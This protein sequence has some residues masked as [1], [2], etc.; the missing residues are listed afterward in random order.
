MSDDLVPLPDDGRRYS[1]AREVRLADASLTGRLRLDALAR[2]LQDIANDDARDAIGQD[3]AA[4]VVRKTTVDVMSW[5]R[6]Q[7]SIELT[8]FCGGVGGRW[9]ERSTSFRG[10]D[11]GHVE[12]AALWVHIDIGSG[13]PVPLPAVFHE[14]FGGGWGSRRVSGRLTHPGPPDVA[15]TAAPWHFRATDFDVMGHVN[16]A[17]YWAVVEEVLVAEAVALPLRFEL[18]YRLPVEP[19]HD[20]SLVEKDGIA[21]LIGAGGV[22]ASAR[23]IP[24]P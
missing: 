22:H 4:W 5:P 24:R 18:E 9:A 3:A 19:H 16:N 7:E 10:R 15:G 1:T 14:Q 12:A 8:T 11:G 20:V 17:A 2:Y 13:R 23:V 6:F 21:W